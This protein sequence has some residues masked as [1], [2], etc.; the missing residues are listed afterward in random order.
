[1]TNAADL[2]DTETAARLAG[3]S[4]FTLVCWRS[5]K[6]ADAPAFVRLT[7]KCVRYRREDV[8]AWILAHRTDPSL[9]NDDD[10]GAQSTA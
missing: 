2:I 8:E 6:I 4:A 9:D 5:R 7:K 3:V 10:T 1:M